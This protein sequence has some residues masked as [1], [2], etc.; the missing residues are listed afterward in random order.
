MVILHSMWLILI[1]VVHDLTFTLSL[2]L[3]ARES[4]VIPKIAIKLG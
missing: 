2:L 1:T 3:T 4:L